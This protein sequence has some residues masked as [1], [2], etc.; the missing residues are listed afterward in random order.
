VAVGDIYA[1]YVD[2][3]M[4]IAGPQCPIFVLACCM[5]FV[6]TTLLNKILNKMNIHGVKDVRQTEIH[7]A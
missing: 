2:F 5:L 6:L 1:E 4:S 7:T 3:S